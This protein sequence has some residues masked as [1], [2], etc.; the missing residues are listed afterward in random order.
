MKNL[1]LE[2]WII[3]HAFLMVFSGILVLMVS[4]LEEML[5]LVGLSFLVLILLNRS[6]FKQFTPYGG[7]ANWVSL[8]RLLLLFF[9]LINSQ[10]LS[11]YTLFLGLL[12]CIGLDGVDGWLARRYEQVSDWGGLF[13]KE[14]DSFLVWSLSLSLY[15]YWEVPIWIIGIGCL[16]YL[17]EILLYL[18]QWQSIKTPKNPIGQYVAAALFISLLGPFILP[19]QFAWLLLSIASMGTLLSFSISFI[20]KYQNANKQPLENRTRNL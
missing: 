9:L 4:S 14:I 11:K 6:S 5:I 1:N 3:I 10:F 15:L 8:I 17:Y 12:L 2:K 19:K 13:D 20:F 16:H 18:L 7:Y